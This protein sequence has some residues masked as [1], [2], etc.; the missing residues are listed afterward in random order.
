MDY[1]NQYNKLIERAKSRSLSGYTESH[2][3]I[4][5][6]MGGTD[7]QD[8]LV[9]L[10]AREH[11]IAHLLLVKIYPNKYTLI[12]AVNMMCMGHSEHR[13]ANRMYGWLRERF[14]SEMSRSQTGTG[15]SQFG[16]KWIYNPVLKQNKRILKTDSIPD[17]WFSGRVLDFDLY[18]ESLRKKEQNKL[19][20]QKNNLQKEFDLEQRKK[21][22]E[23]E[24]TEYKN[25]IL[26]L[27]DLYKSG[28]YYSINEFHKINKLSISRMTI[29]NYW[30]KYIPEYKENSKEGKRYR[31]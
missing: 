8:N 2:H 31:I 21:Q 19:E 23:I 13:S 11:Y 26:S 28:N 20:R 9:E 5:R 22:K 3:I 1:K 6:C 10:T 25:Y 4:P 18:S 29:T 15:N 12:K 27:Y 30:L 14:S 17:G 24:K 16:K 7:S